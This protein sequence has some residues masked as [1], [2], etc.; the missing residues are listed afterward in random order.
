M[1][2]KKS[3]DFLKFWGKF[4]ARILSRKIRYP[5]NKLYGPNDISFESHL[6]AESKNIF[7][8]KFGSTLIKLR[9]FE[10][11]G[12]GVCPPLGPKW[13]LIASRKI[14]KGKSKNIIEAGKSSSSA[15]SA[16]QSPS[17]LSN[18]QNKILTQNL[19]RL[20]PAHV[21]Q[22]ATHPSTS[23]VIYKI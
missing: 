15:R 7:S 21:T 20:P 2:H 12:G 10:V 4:L 13:I 1:V 22:S 16:P 6:R 11:L 5:K 9:G 3:Y 17:G 8:K 19:L 23:F 18:A 14:K